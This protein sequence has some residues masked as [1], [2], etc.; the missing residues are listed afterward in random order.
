MIARLA[1]LALVMLSACAL[2]PWR[3]ESRLVEQWRQDP[4]QTRA[5]P[6]Q[7]LPHGKNPAA[8]LAVMGCKFA[9]AQADGGESFPADGQLPSSCVRGFTGSGT[10]VSSATRRIVRVSKSNPYD[11]TWAVRSGRTG[12]ENSKGC[13]RVVFYECSSRHRATQE[14]PK[15]TPR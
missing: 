3:E 7:L 12:T 15:A 1:P 14:L 2:V 13:D 9:W 10:S 6:A 5:V 8:D 4:E 11:R